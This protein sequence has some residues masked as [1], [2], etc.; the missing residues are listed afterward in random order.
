MKFNTN[1]YLSTVTTVLITVLLYWYSSTGLINHLWLGKLSFLGVDTGSGFF[2]KVALYFLFI[3]SILEIFRLKRETGR[4]EDGISMDLLDV[5]IEY[6]IPGLQKTVSKM[7][8]LERKHSLL[9]ISLIGSACRALLNSESTISEGSNIVNS[10]LAI[11]RKRLNSQMMIISNLAN[12]MI[13]I[14]LIGSLVGISGSMASLPNLFG[15]VDPDL[16]T[17]N[18]QSIGSFLSSAW[19]TTLIGFVLSIVVKYLLTKTNDRA[20][21]VESKLELYIIENLFSRLGKGGRAE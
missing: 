10:L 13:A 19:N 15:N 1:F 17:K 3:F 8:N 14:G 2:I 4:E 6:D 7:S 20:I 16:A 5:S 9:L 12:T 18:I 11:H 21:Q